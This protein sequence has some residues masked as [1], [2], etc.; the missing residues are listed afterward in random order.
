[1]ECDN[2]C[3]EPNRALP[4]L[5]FFS[6]SVHCCYRL[7]RLRGFSS[8]VNLKTGSEKSQ[9]PKAV[10]VPKAQLPTPQQ[11]AMPGMGWGEWIGKPEEGQRSQKSWWA[12]SYCTATGMQISSKGYCDIRKVRQAQGAADTLL[13]SGEDFYLQTQSTQWGGLDNVTAVHSCKSVIPGHGWAKLSVK[14]IWAMWF[15]HTCISNTWDLEGSGFLSLM[16][17]DLHCEF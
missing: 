4:V 2:L 11:A 3:K 15:T 12:A 1:M 8:V 17:L 13:E 6:V 14:W 5:C 7:I 9:P 10:Y 16:Q